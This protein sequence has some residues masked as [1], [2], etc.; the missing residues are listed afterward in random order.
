MRKI[1]QTDVN[2]YYTNSNWVYQF[3]YY[4]YETLSMHHGFWNSHTK[5]IHEASLNVNDVV[6]QLAGCNKSKRVLDAGCGV[7][8]TAIYLAKKYGCHV[9]GITINPPQVVK[10]NN[11]AAKKGVSDLVSFSVGDYTKTKFADNTFDCVY[12]I[13][14]VCYSL[15]KLAFTK[16]AFR[17]LKPNGKL[18]IVD[19]YIKRQAK[20]R[21]ERKLTQDYLQAFAL[22]EAASEADMKKALV[23]AKF[24]EIRAINKLKEV[25]PTINYIYKLAKRF[26]WFVTLIKPLPFGFTQG[27]VAN[28]TALTLEMEAHKL[29]MFDYYVHVATKK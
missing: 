13:E 24:K 28:Y 1:T 10:A 14:S 3:F 11:Y 2:T 26:E 16:E 15:P 6:A 20:N 17:I 23:D 4:S 7:G 21:F 8:G 19:G 18:I 25:E 27:V 5:T 22:S 9:E 29:G 12:A